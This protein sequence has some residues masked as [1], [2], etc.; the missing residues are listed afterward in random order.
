LADED[1]RQRGALLDDPGVHRLDEPVP[2]D[3]I[4]LEGQDA[5]FD[6][7]FVYLNAQ[8]ATNGMGATPLFQPMPRGASVF[9]P[10][11]VG[12]FRDGAHIP[13]GAPHWRRLWLAWAPDGGI[14]GHVDLRGR[15]E[16]LAAAHRCLLGM[17]VAPGWRARGLGARL[18]AEACAQAQALGLAWID[19][20]VLAANAPARRLYARCGFVQTGEIVDMFRVDGTAHAYVFLSRRIGA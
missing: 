12:T 4:R 7:F 8:L 19:L 5:D 11:R 14:A 6:A 2:R 20:E 18:V 1:L 16:A 15:S 9:P 3:E 10:G 17:G 13:V